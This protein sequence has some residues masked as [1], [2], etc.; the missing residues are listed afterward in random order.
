MLLFVAQAGASPV[1]T[2]NQ[3]RT[4]VDLARL[5]TSHDGKTLPGSF[6]CT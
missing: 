3:G 2:D 4:P 5:T 1:K 6:L